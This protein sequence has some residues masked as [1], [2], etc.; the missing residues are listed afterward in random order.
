M[1]SS[2]DVALLSNEQQGSAFKRGTPVAIAAAVVC[3]L[4]V[5]LQSQ[6]Q[7]MTQLFSTTRAPVMRATQTTGVV[8]SVRVSGATTQRPFVAGTP[9]PASAHAVGT[10]AGLASSAT[11][12]TAP[13][14]M[15]ATLLALPAMVFG[16]FA[17]RSQKATTDVFGLSLDDDL[18]VAILPATSEKAAPTEGATSTMRTR[19]APSPTGSLHVGGARTALYNWLVAKKT[20]G[21]FVLRIEDTDVAR[22][23]RESEESMKAD[24][25]WLGL[26]WDEGPDLDLPA[27]NCG[28]FRQSERGDIYMDMAKTLM[29]TVD[30]EGKKVAYACF[31]TQE[32]L[33]A[34]KLADE[35]AGLSQS[36]FVSPWRD[37]SEEEV[38]AKIAAGEEYAIRFRVPPGKRVQIEDA[39]RG[40]VSWDVNAT[41]GDF[42]LLR[43]SGV[44]VYNFCVAVDDALMGVSNV[45]RA[46][47]HLTNTVRQALILEA[48]GFTMPDY[49]H[50]S[51]ILGEDGSKLSKRH[52]ATSVA[53]FAEEGFV[54]SAMINYLVG[55]GWNDGTDKDVYT[56]EEVIDAF[57]VDRVQKS[58]STFDMSKLKWVNGQ[59]IKLME[60]SELAALLGPFLVSAGVAKA[61]DSP[62]A[63]AAASMSK[64]KI[65][66]LVEAV[67]LVKDALA[68]DFA[69]TVVEDKKAAALVEEDLKGLVTALLEAYDAGE[70]PD[71]KSP[72]FSG[73]FGKW[74]KAFGKATG[75]K[76]KGLFMP[77]RLVLTGTMSGPDVGAQLALAGAAEADGV[78]CVT[79]AERMDALRTW[80]ASA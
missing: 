19:F 35:K 29:D 71:A 44:P 65:D 5:V 67:D 79:V 52:G 27:E 68:Y 17:W 74:I 16:L 43:S 63:V 38:A 14:A 64:Q 39:V 70:F 4:M 12:Y 13:P 59:H 23:T 75:R 7:S 28:P 50:C 26:D 32:E 45:I 20:G 55:L 69:T 36:L 72:E 30:S 18:R 33:N 77:I 31:C 46:E 2:Y 76:G 62:V 15:W 25:R 9:A 60:D 80:A 58:P 40:T 11:P 6:G 54:P 21:K 57:S 37:A 78:P 24:L 53:Q 8:G 34:K 22:S 61:P 42:V 10:Q 48:L 47:E 51:L 1:N 73:E 66:L 3:G 41:I 49:A 56:V